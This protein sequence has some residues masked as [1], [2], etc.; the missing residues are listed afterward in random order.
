MFVDLIFDLIR[1]IIHEDA[2][3]RVR[4]AHLCLWP[5]KRWEE[6][7]VQECG[8]WILELLRDIAREAEVWVLINCTRNETWDVGHLSE[9]VRE[10]V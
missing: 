2:R 8:L 4:R 1:R 3:V 9:N 6:S 5:L 7:R 10:G